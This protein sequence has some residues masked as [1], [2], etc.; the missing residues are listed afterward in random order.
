MWVN[1]HLPDYPSVSMN[2]N[3]MRYLS[4]PTNTYYSYML[5]NCNES[6]IIEFP[7]VYSVFFSYILLYDIEAEPSVKLNIEFSDTQGVKY[8]Q[9]ITMKAVHDRDTTL[10]S[11]STDEELDCFGGTRKLSEDESPDTC[12]GISYTITMDYSTPI[13]K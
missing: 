11:P 1:Y 12:Y 9:I 3:A 2:D 5:P 6:Y 7:I 8:H 13:Q 4:I 10:A